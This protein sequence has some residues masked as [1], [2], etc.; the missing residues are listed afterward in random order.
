VAPQA[1]NVRPVVLHKIAAVAASADMP[2]GAFWAPVF[3]LKIL[4]PGEDAVNDLPAV[5]TAAFDGSV[6]AGSPAGPPVSDDGR[7]A[8][9]AACCGVLAIVDA[10]FA[11]GLTDWWAVGPWLPPRRPVR[12]DRNHLK[13]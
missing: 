4:A 9:H 3:A 6:K 8:P 2:S 7:G 11:M 1:P 5:K 13:K 12:R 10:I